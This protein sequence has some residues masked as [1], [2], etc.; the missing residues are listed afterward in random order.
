MDPPRRT[1]C[2]LLTG[3]R[4]PEDQAKPGR[5]VEIE[6]VASEIGARN[7]SVPVIRQGD[8]RIDRSET[9]VAYSFPAP[10]L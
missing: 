7:A 2:C 3:V 9:E 8:D 1:G 10:A 5:R 4:L 6:I